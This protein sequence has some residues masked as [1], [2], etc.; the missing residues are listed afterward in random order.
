MLILTLSPTTIFAQEESPVTFEDQ[1]A[2]FTYDQTAPFD[3][4]QV[5]TE[6]R[7]GVTVQDITFVGV[8][9]SSDPV[10]AYLVTPSGEGPFAGILWA[11]WL[12]EEKSDASQ[13]LDEAVELAKSGVVSVLPNAMWSKPGW[14]ENRVLPEDFAN[15]IK[16]VIEFRRAMDLL[17]SQPGVD[18]A[19]LAFVGHDYGGMY[20]TLA[21]GLDQKAKAYVF[22]A[23]TP[24]IL[25]WAFFAAE[26]ESRV[27]YIRQNA[28]LEPMDYLQQI[29]NA[30][31]LFQFS[32][33]D[34]FVGRVKGGEFFGNA[35]DP[36]ERKIYD[37]TDHSMSSDQV[38][39]D[40][41]VWLKT[42]LGLE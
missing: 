19:R 32:S 28:M 14:Y 15:G 17:I 36:K 33:N 7:E 8:P 6:D 10:R 24:S 4:Q 23:V 37:D 22:I 3:V 1:A 34:I 21:A 31:F 40:R 11:H 30:S 25:D 29:K 20:G 27:D 38:K 12:G 39:L 16:Q 2:L 9:G 18:A 41:D 5:S 13:Y 42:Q 26:P 35:A